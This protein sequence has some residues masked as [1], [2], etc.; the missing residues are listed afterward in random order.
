M[1][2][3][4]VSWLLMQIWR[5]LMKTSMVSNV[6]FVNYHF[7][8]VAKGYITLTMCDNSTLKAAPCD[9][10]DEKTKKRIKNSG[11]DC[12]CLCIDESSMICRQKVGWMEHRVSESRRTGR[13]LDENGD[14][15][16]SSNKWG[17]IKI[18]QFCGDVM[19]LPP[20]KGTPHY[21][22]LLYDNQ[23]D[24]SHGVGKVVVDELLNEFVVVMDEV[25]RQE[26]GPWLDAIENIRNGTVTD[27]D[28][29]FLKNRD[30][31]NLSPEEK[32]TFEKEAIFLFPTWKEALAT[33]V[34]YI[35]AIKYVGPPYNDDT[36]DNRQPVAICHAICKRETGRGQVHSFKDCSLP[37][38]TFLCIGSQVV[39]LR[40]HVVE[41]NAYNGLIGT[42]VAIVYKNNERGPQD[43]KSLPAYVVV[44]FPDYKCQGEPWD[45]RNPTHLPVVPVEQRC[46]K[47]CCSK[48]Q[49]PLIVSK[50]ST[51]HKAQGI[52]VGPNQIWKY[53]VLSIGE[54]ACPTPGLVYVGISRAGKVENFAFHD[55]PNDYHARLL[56]TGTGEAYKDRVR[57][58]DHLKQLSSATI[59]KWTSLITGTSLSFE[60]GYNK[61]I[62]DFNTKFGSTF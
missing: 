35:N 27:D 20:V 11:C 4:C 54:K 49:L 44:D 9:T 59:T 51:I 28:I 22:S 53:L 17:G 62:E 38:V 50:A 7:T 8:I 18:V 43:G 40:N 39:L 16:N 24:G 30:L 26:R 42:V 1:N 57:F 61:L 19:Q 5:K 21:S 31:R 13:V 36:I 56:K 15:R 2:A 3:E 41:E 48:I 29:N 6:R 23:I 60:E 52:T 33:M 32:E 46:E 10:R 55:L 14:I 45:P 34:K 47:K 58:M 37:N 25:V 12:E